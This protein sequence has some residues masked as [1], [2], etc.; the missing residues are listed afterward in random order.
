MV[1]LTIYQ[2]Y[3]WIGFVVLGL[4]DLYLANFL[5]FHPIVMVS[6]VGWFWNELHTGL[7]VGGMLELIFG[8]AQFTK[9][10][11]LNLVLFAGG[12]VIYINQQTYNINLFLSLTLGLLIAFGLQLL[13][14][15][16]QDWLKWFVLVMASGIIVF[17][18]PFGR[19][20]FGLIPAQLLNQMAVA[21]GIV[22]WIFFAY[23]I[24]G[25]MRRNY[26]KEIVIG[27]PAILVGSILN[28]KSFMWG[29][30]AFI[31]IFYLLYFV[32]ERA[33]ARNRELS[34]LKWI[35]LSLIFCGI[36][37]LLPNLTQTTLWVFAGLLGLNLLLLVRNFAPLEIYLI[38]FLAGIILTQGGYLY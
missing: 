22:P 14:E 4:I 36:Y 29:S 9:T 16:L 33:Y 2:I 20:L 27:I 24:W 6:A 19:E 30:L 12:L 32:L 1:R 35:N 34:A 13:M 18:L 23:A 10:R 7:I 17:L 25:L 11:R 8:I 3:L 38:V 15:P 37:L 28:M 21:G 31:V 26:K 5:I